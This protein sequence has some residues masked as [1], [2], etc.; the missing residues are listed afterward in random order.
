MA[1][2]VDN[3]TGM[4]S[5]RY[6]GTGQLKQYGGTQEQFVA[7]STEIVNEAAAVM[8]EC[9]SE[10]YAELFNFIITGMWEQRAEMARESGSIDADHFGQPRFVQ[11]PAVTLTIATCVGQYGYTSLAGVAATRV[12]KLIEQLEP[13]IQN[14]TF[15][16]Q[17][18]SQSSVVAG[19]PCRTAVEV[20][21]TTLSL[22]FDNAI[23]M[24]EAMEIPV[25][26]LRQD[27]IAETV[28]AAQKD[29]AKL[30]KFKQ[31][32]PK[33]YFEFVTG[34]VAQEFVA[35]CPTHDKSGQPQFGNLKT[36]FI[37]V[38]NRVAFDPEGTR[39]LAI[40][41][42][43]TFAYFGKMGGQSRPPQDWMRY[44]KPP[45]RIIHQDKFLVEETLRNMG[46]VFTEAMQAPDL[47]TLKEKVA[48]LRWVYAN[49]M[50]CRRGDGAVGDWLELAIYQAKGY[51]VRF[52]QEKMPN[53]EPLARD[54]K[55][56]LENYDSTIIIEGPSSAALLETV[57]DKLPTGVGVNLDK[58]E[59]ER[60]LET[61][62]DS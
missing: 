11:S 10:R 26:G 27:Q 55:D 59:L 24:L 46:R 49:S 5:S 3:N 21:E 60:L 31:N 56:Y 40:S 15:G 33:L 9:P 34:I 30:L 20:L 39:A 37:V 41:R 51:Q 47:K 4:F 52:N 53:A 29:R 17:K 32:N 44:F 36:H 38:T 45:G 16:K 12:A 61:G 48:V 23:A 19:F 58:G 22:S 18:I 43:M 35:K 42:Y 13:N 62:T 1:S 54:L 28:D 6:I 57:L 2:G 7:K 25:V 8:R 50:P 14:G